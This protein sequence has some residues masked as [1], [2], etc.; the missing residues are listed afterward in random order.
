MLCHYHIIASII[1]Y[2]DVALRDDIRYLQKQ[3]FLVGRWWLTS[4]AT[5]KLMGEDW[6]K[7]GRESITEPTAIKARDYDVNTDGNSSNRNCEDI[8]NT[9]TYVT[10][11]YMVSVN[12]L[13]VACKLA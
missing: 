10:A 7:C 13:S 4:D 1:L 5:N 3:N 2:M 11:Y 12:A 6:E 9:D 8:S